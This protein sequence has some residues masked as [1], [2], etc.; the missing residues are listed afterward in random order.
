MQGQLRSPENLNQ[1]IISGQR[2]ARAYHK[3]DVS[4]VIREVLQAF[5]GNVDLVL[6]VVQVAQ[7]HHNDLITTLLGLERQVREH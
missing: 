3:R 7:V 2:S 6:G 4:D 1:K 5:Q